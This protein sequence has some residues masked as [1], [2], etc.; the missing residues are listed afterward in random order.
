[1]FCVVMFKFKKCYYLLFF[2]VR[3]VCLG[4]VLNDYGIIYSCLWDICKFVFIIMK[5]SY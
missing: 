4:R 5:L 3:L 1:M 2:V